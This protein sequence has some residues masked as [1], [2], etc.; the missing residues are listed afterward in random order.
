MNE[1]NLQI[2][3]QISFSQDT[4]IIDE[5]RIAPSRSFSKEAFENIIPAKKN[6]KINFLIILF[7]ITIFFQLNYIIGEYNKRSEAIKRKETE[8]KEKIYREKQNALRKQAENFTRDAKNTLE[9][10]QGV[11]K[12]IHENRKNES[13]IPDKYKEAQK[14]YESAMVYFKQ[15]KYERAS[16]L[17]VNSINAGNIA[18]NYAET[19]LSNI[20]KQFDIKTQEE[21]KLLIQIAK[22]REEIKI[23]IER[24]K[25]YLKKIAE[26]DPERYAPI[27]FTE[28]KR[29]LL[30]AA[31]I[32]NE[33]M[34]SKEIKKMD[35]SL[36][37]ANKADKLAK[38]CDEEIEKARQK[39]IEESRRK[40]A[41]QDA[42][43]VRA[44]WEKTQK[45]KTNE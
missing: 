36:N 13:Y 29:V 30:D 18:I 10:I 3:T 23:L 20:H 32:Y 28:A 41:L 11:I 1:H 25:E 27:T 22:K 4:S 26:K 7:G 45:K 5:M 39:F 44:E 21:E 6:K 38:I 40:A 16:K 43:K 14:I 9:K 2:D 8:E 17:A 33:T 37:L 42:L 19:E 31:R 34:N 12:E 35:E 24:A 15:S